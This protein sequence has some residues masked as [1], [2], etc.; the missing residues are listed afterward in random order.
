MKKTL[1]LLLTLLC[2]LSLCSLPTAAV[3]EPTLINSQTALVYC[4]ESDTILYEK[5]IDEQV[6]PAALVKLMTAVVA[7]ENAEAAG[8]TLDS[9][10][11][12]TRRAY[13]AATGNTISIKVGEQLRLRDLLGAMILTGAND[14]ALVIS[15]SVG[16]TFEGFVDLMNQKAAEIGMENTVYG[17]CTGIHHGAM[18]TTPRDLLTLAAYV[19][20]IPYLT[21]LCAEPR[22]VIPATNLSEERILGTRNYLVSNRVNTDYYVPMARGMI[23]GSTQEAGYCAIGSAQH[24]GLNYISIVT[25]AGY[26]PILKEEGRIEFDEEGNEVLIPPVYENRLDGLVDAGQLLIWAEGNFDYMNLVDRTTP[27]VQVPVKL[28]KGVDCVTLMPESAI[29]MYVPRDLDRKKDL[30][31]TWELDSEELIAP[32]KAGQQVGMLTVS[33]LGEEIGRVPLIVRNTIERDGG[34]AIVSRFAELATTPF[35]LLIFGLIAF[36]AVFYVITTA[37]AR[38]KRQTAPKRE[39]DKNTRYLK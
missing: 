13:D 36:A 11:T 8:L 1:S 33:Y 24:D 19:A 14:A 4:L 3:K 35:F 27:V 21:E 32:V 22:I 6:Y 38:Q 18:V 31:L 37:I 39:R 20:R 16:G 12:A 15:E 29:E 23:C 7:F 28:G 30:T 2:L 17:N 5:G 25:G 9:Y 34:L 26:T 10:L